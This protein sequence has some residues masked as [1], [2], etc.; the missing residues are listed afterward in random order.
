MSGIYLQVI[1]HLI[2][3]RPE[4]DLNMTGKSKTLWND[5]ER[6]GKHA[7]LEPVSLDGYA[8]LYSFPRW[9]SALRESLSAG[10]PV[11]NLADLIQEKAEKLLEQVCMPVQG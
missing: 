5:A 2:L 11:P 1:D 8:Q 6:D 4:D 7:R 3:L 9:L 10:A